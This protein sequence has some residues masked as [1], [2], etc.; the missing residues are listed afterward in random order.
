MRWSRVDCEFLHQENTWIEETKKLARAVF[1][2]A[3]RFPEPVR[4]DGQIPRMRGNDGGNNSEGRNNRDHPFAP[5]CGFCIA[6]RCAMQQHGTS[7]QC[8][9]YVRGE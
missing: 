9:R 2:A 1:K 5:A 6:S 4:I 7:E 8:D 3:D